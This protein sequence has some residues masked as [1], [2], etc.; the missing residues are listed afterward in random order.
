MTSLDDKIGAEVV[1]H[2]GITD[3][4]QRKRYSVTHRKP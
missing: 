4:S 1:K 2:P 3:R